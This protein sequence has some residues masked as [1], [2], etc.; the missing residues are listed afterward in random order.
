MNE[1]DIY[2]RSIYTILNIIKIDDS[3]MIFTNGDENKIVFERID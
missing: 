1:H 3:G 2:P